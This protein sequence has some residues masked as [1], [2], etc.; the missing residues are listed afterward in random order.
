MS[1][2]VKDKVKA[3]YITGLEVTKE[4]V[5]Q[6]TCDICWESPESGKLVDFR[7]GITVCTICLAEN[8]VAFLLDNTMMY[9]VDVQKCG[10]CENA[11]VLL[12]DIG[13]CPECQISYNNIRNGGK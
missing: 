10:F 8:D 7:G 11:T 12:S 9:K 2:W 4:D 6:G 5:E 1:C 13:A 3:N